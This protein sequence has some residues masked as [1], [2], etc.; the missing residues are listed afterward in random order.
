[1]SGCAGRRHAA[2]DDSIE[3]ASR[4]FHKP[5]QPV[6]TSIGRQAGT[7]AEL[8]VD[9]VWMTSELSYHKICH[10]NPPPKIHLQIRNRD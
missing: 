3:P 4:A 6:I 9:E 8:L 7:I 1:M 10:K 5:C 2:T